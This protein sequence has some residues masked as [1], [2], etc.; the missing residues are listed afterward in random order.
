MEPWKDEMRQ[1]F[2]AASDGGKSGPG[3]RSKSSFLEH[4]LQ[5]LKHA[6]KNDF[7]L[8]ASG[9][10]GEDLAFTQREETM[11]EIMD[12]LASG[13]LEQLEISNRMHANQTALVRRN[14]FSPPRPSPRTLPRQAAGALAPPKRPRYAFTTSDNEDDEDDEDGE[15]KDL[16]INPAAAATHRAPLEPDRPGA[17]PSAPL[18]ENSALDRGGGSGFLDTQGPLRFKTATELLDRFKDQRSIDQQRFHAAILATCIPHIYGDDSF[19]QHR[20]R[21]LKETGKT[22]FPLACLIMCPRR[23]G[24]TVSV[25]MIAAVL[26][27]VC[28]RLT[29]VILSTGQKISTKLMKR[30]IEYF[31]QLPNASERI[32]INNEKKFLVAAPGFVGSKAAAE[33]SNSYNS[34][35]AC[36]ANIQGIKG[37]E[38]NLFLI[39]EAARVPE[40]IIGEGVA[41]MLMKK[42]TVAV[43]ISTNTGRDNFFTQL[44]NPLPSGQEHLEKRLLKFHVN[45]YCDDCRRRG[46]DPRACDHNSDR[47]PPWLDSRNQDYTQI[48]MSNKA[49][50]LREVLGGVGEE[51]DGILDRGDVDC[52]LA[53]A[54]ALWRRFS[55]EEDGFLKFKRNS[56]D[57]AEIQARQRRVDA[58]FELATKFGFAVP[59]STYVAQALTFIDPDGGGSQSEYAIMTLLFHP[60]VPQP[61]IIGMASMSGR[62]KAP[63]MNQFFEQYIRNIKSHPAY[64][65]FEQNFYIGMESNYGGSVGVQSILSLHF[66][67]KIK[68]IELRDPQYI[69]TPK[70]DS[71]GLRTTKE[72]KYNGAQQLMRLISLRTEEKITYDLESAVKPSQPP[73]SP[74]GA[75]KNRA[76]PKPKCGLLL[77]ANLAFAG[78][79]TAGDLLE[80]LRDQLLRLKEK[81]GSYFAKEPP[82]KKDDMVMCLIL[83]LYWSHLLP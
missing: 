12:I 23:W 64:P 44:F 39:D 1:L 65:T 26:M 60:L 47:Y 24:K 22:C 19:E 4:V 83:A 58:S 43:L 73:S 51:I 21:I 68:F 66:E 46:V 32:L 41:P 50:Y 40:I 34:I 16:H 9:G 25:S 56:D 72:V 10:G 63:L 18:L 42:N 27:Y 75:G 37:I 38:A 5:S 80:E 35:E 48:F 13:H 30:V 70:E 82:D 2:D 14:L 36:A 74:T 17:G 81:N 67:G 78:R 20:L 6:E 31:V 15:K 71:S 8:L 29:I 77:A 11:D 53:D 7:F 28:P 33:R 49:L 62:C 45:L 79:P 76:G 54:I 61:V 57:A 69:N 55:S 52:L 3:P 59:K